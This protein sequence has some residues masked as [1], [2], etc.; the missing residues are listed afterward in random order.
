MPMSALALRKRSRGLAMTLLKLPS[1]PTCAVDGN[2]VSYVLSHTVLFCADY[3]LG[4][5]ACEKASSSAVRGA[6]TPQ[7]VNMPLSTPFAP[8]LC[9]MSSMV[10]PGQGCV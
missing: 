3:S 5:L 6:R 8:I 4:A 9:P 2:R 10:T 1:G 7:K